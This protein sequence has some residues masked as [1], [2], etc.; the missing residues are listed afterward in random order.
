MIAQV[1]TPRRKKRFANACKGKLCLGAQFGL[2][3][4]LFGKS[5]PWRFYAA[6]T[7][8]LELN[9][10]TAWAAG[11]ANPEELNS[12]L[13]F[14][15]CE[16]V[17]LDP[18]EC[19]PSAG[20]SL[21]EPLTIFGLEPWEQLQLPPVEAA[22]WNRFVLDTDPPAMEV[23]QVLYPSDPQQRDDFYSELCTKRARGKALV[24]ALRQN[25]TIACTVGA[26]S[27][28]AGQGY[29][30]CGQT[31]EALRGR[32]IGGRLIVQM[33]NALAEKGLRP[34]FLCKPERVRLYTRLGFH[35]L[36]ELAKYQINDPDR[37]E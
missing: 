16:S 8:A 28:H 3:V 13:R 17:I 29:M 4:D 15:G 31:A 10:S 37:K 19:P 5:Q 25:G 1:N 18:A 26:Y 11:H 6:P 36:G 21:A 27:L 20:W 35:K 22:L 2:D 34:V 7:L 9:G 23:A 12:F 24:W 30:A 33:A 14:C 32:G